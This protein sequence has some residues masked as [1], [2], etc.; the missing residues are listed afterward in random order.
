VMFLDRQINEAAA[1]RDSKS[2]MRQRLPVTCK[3]S[4]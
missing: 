4:P 1:A 3:V 2:R